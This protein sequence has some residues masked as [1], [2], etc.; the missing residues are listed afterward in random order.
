MQAA[1]GRRRERSKRL[2]RGVKEAEEKMAI[3]LKKIYQVFS[4][5]FLLFNIMKP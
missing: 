2:I 1:V 4:V 5:S 3:S